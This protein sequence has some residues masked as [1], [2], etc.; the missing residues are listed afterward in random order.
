MAALNAQPSK[1]IAGNAQA[2][3]ARFVNSA[4]TTTPQIQLAKSVK[5]DV[6]HALLMLPVK[7]AKSDIFLLHPQIHAHYV[8]L[9]VPLAILH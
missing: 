9:P 5:K 7:V 8:P 4:F 6:S 3:V 2:Q 1:R